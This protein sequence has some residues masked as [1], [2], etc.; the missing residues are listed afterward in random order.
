[1]R[2]ETSTTAQL[3]R[4]ALNDCYFLKL[5]YLKFNNEI[6]LRQKEVCANL[7]TYDSAR[8]RKDL[9]TEQPTVVGVVTFS[10]S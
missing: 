8:A 4:N 9:R 2:L 1:M 6:R 7:Q 10:L 5:V 3:L